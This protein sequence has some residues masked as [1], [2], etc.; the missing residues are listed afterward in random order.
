MQGRNKGACARAAVDGFAGGVPGD[1]G[2]HGA[3]HVGCVLCGHGE[4]F[5]RVDA[6]QDVAYV[7]ACPSNVQTG[8]I[9]VW[10]RRRHVDALPP[11][12]LEPAALAFNKEVQMGARCL[13]HD[14]GA[15]DEER[16]GEFA[17]AYVARIHADVPAQLN[18]R[19][20]R[21]SRHG[22]ARAVC[23][24][25]RQGRALPFHLF[26]AFSFFVAFLSF[27]TQPLDGSV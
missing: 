27:C 10:W 23:L 22:K 14:R 17:S 21:I 13:K 8:R 2:H 20:G 16:C 6:R 4:K 9:R 1:A 11:G 19:R 26:F 7:A 5:G 3:R 18:A 12:R 25:R 15:V 24:H